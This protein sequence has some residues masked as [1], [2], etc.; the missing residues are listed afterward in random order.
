MP[1]GK[2]LTAEFCALYLAITGTFI[3]IGI[4]LLVA[5]VACM[6]ISFAFDIQF[7]RARDHHYA[8][9]SYRCI[10][11]HDSYSYR[12]ISALPSMVVFPRARL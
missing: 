9:L 7:Y 1:P 10:D 4:L 3:Y 6:M 8:P 11:A 2:R 12:Y 5:A